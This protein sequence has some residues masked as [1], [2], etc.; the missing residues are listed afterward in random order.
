MQRF[1]IS[2]TLGKSSV[3]H[4]TNI[5]HSNREFIARNVD[6]AR[7]HQNVLY[8]RQDVE[9]AY[10]KLFDAA[11]KEYNEKQK[12]ADRK[13]KDYYAHVMDGKREEAYYEAIVQFGDSKTAP[14]GSQTGLIAQQMLDEYVHSFQKRNPHLYVF[15][16]VMHL[17][18]TSPHL[19][20]H[21]IPFYTTPRKNGLHVGVSMRQA[22]IEQGFSSKGAQGNQLVAWEESERNYM[23]KILHQHGFE[24]DD[25]NAKYAHMTVEE[26]KL[27]QD[28][29]KKI[30]ELREQGHIS[31]HD[32][33]RVRTQQLF[34]KLA[35]VEQN[36][37]RL[38]NEK[39]SP[40]KSFYY[41]SPEQHSFMISA[42]EKEGI[43]Y[44]ETDNGFE[45]QA[46]YADAIRKIEKQYKP[47]HISYREVL[48]DDVDRLLMQSKTLEELLERLQ[49]CGYSVRRGKYLAVKPKAAEN[50]IRLKSLGEFYSEFA[51][52]NRLRAKAKFEHDLDARIQSQPD[53]LAPG[54]VVLRTMQFYIVTY[55]G[56]ALPM[57]RSNA[58]KPYAWTNDAAL[59][60]LLALNKKISAGATLDSLRSDFA[61]Q[62]QKVSGLDAAMQEQKAAL[63]SYLEL[64]EKIGV[65]FEG[66]PSS[67]FSPEQA[68]SDLRRIPN[69]A[70]DNYRNI[71]KLLDSET[72]HLRKLERDLAAETEKL[73]SASELVTAME[74]ALGGT[75]VQE[76]VAEEQKRRMMAL[77][78]NGMKTVE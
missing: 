5:A 78:P 44:R 4:Q 42:M 74:Q 20:I 47:Q 32:L 33:S 41:S 29:K 6:Q 31:D 62:E 28:A 11:V 2:F 67:I 10:H 63:R 65:V 19:H 38:E 30:A 7:T 70:E 22:L 60:R 23:E 76:L 54:T 34:A 35:A 68:R 56:G 43:P 40:Y 66:K 52:K 1:S 16:A 21:F 48:R 73:R 58:K 26:Y 49:R 57:R 36:N 3:A 50:F 24:R 17:D 37:V 46:C 55:S 75:F 51:L 15:N 8:Q 69:I 9:D 72:E 61:A 18:E 59:D 39:H 71:D 27:E 53:R 64:K 45:A 12:R 13:I 77:L 25:K 14:C